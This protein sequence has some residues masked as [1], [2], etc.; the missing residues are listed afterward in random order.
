M[1]PNTYDSFIPVTTVGRLHDV[2]LH[3]S[4]G[5]LSPSKIASNG[6]ANVQSNPNICPSIMKVQRCLVV[7]EGIVM[8]R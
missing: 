3:L 1:K 5:P 4:L 6:F 7:L 2:L 8:T